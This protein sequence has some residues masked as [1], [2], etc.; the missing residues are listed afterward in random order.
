MMRDSGMQ[1]PPKIT[2]ADWQS[3]VDEDI[4]VS[5]VVELEG[6]GW[7][8]VHSST[9][10]FTHERCDVEVLF[11]SV[12]DVGSSATVFFARDRARSPLPSIAENTRGRPPLEVRVYASCDERL[13]G[14]CACALSAFSAPYACTRGSLAIGPVWG[15][16][17]VDSRLD[18]RTLHRLVQTVS[19]IMSA[20]SRTLRNVEAAIPEPATAGSRPRATDHPSTSSR[21]ASRSIRCDALRTADLA[22]HHCVRS[23]ASSLANVEAATGPTEP[24]LFRLFHGRAPMPVCRHD[25][26]RNAGAASQIITFAGDEVAIGLVDAPTAANIMAAGDELEYVDQMDDESWRQMVSETVI[27]QA[28]VD[29]GLAATGA[30]VQIL[31]A[32]DVSCTSEDLDERVVLQDA[33][34]G[35]HPKL[36]VS[37]VPVAHI[38]TIAHSLYDRLANFDPIT[39]FSTPD[40]LTTLMDASYLADVERARAARARA[41]CTISRILSAKVPRLRAKLWHPNSRLVKC[42]DERMHFE[43]WCDNA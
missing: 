12:A 4:G 41:T 11:E 29:T 24:D 15:I 27:S 36:F 33:G 25:V 10:V 1:R 16:T 42:S 35:L 6:L 14:R 20:L 34:E 2:A 8:S 7:Q 23:I 5:D 40:W 21:D 26:P 28:C 30:S 19:T 43:G 18:A 9:N 31:V 37:G 32:Q 38:A 17:L 39:F 3:A 13:V 22:I